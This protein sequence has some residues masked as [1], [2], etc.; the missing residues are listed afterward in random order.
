MRKIKEVLRLRAFGRSQ[1]EIARSCRMPRRTV[2]M[3][4][5][6]AGA[7]DLSYEDVA[8]WSDGQL[9]AHLFARV[10]TNRRPHPDWGAV[11]SAM[12][13]RAVTLRLLW[14]EYREETPDGLGYTQ[15]V[16]HFRAWEQ[17]QGAARL[18]QQF[19][20]GDRVEV[21]YA[22]MTIQV[23]LGAESRPAQVFVGVLPYSAY[24]FADVTETQSLGD[25]IA[26]HIR[27]FEYLGGVPRSIVPDNLKAGV[28][29]ACFYDPTINLTYRDLAIH[30][31]TAVIPTRVRRPRDKGAVENAVGQVERRAL[32]PLRHHQF[33]SVE[34]AR[35]AVLA[36]VAVINAAMLTGV[37]GATRQGLF[38]ETEKPTLRALPPDRF[39]HGTWS[40]CTVRPHYHVEV[41]GVFYSVPYRLIGE[42]VDIH[43]TA[44]L[45]T[46]FR[47]GER[48]ACHRRGTSNAGKHPDGPSITVDAH[49]PANH[50]AMDHYTVEGVAV[51]LEAIGPSSRAVYARQCLDA[52]HPTQAMRLGRGLLRLAARHGAERLEDACAAAL[53]A[54]VSSLRY[55]D[56]LL[57][58]AAAP[59]PANEGVGDHANLRGAAYYS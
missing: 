45:V 7:A 50:R 57:R 42:K 35:S 52:D 46:V 49:R 48:V 47:R 12:R 40:R 14:E 19:A 25:W 27:L 30:Y 43:A 36:K 24:I 34:E 10:P 39:E 38:D 4:L 37:P 15:F 56:T 2:R 9:E 44:Q 29:Q 54:N 53:A 51:E 21:D 16:A 28:T 22:G 20:P 31:G 3:Y 17:E 6:R 5:E 58:Q 41:D 23:G 55:I 8:S 26:S 1:R 59:A 11:A 33:A 13:G 18:R 32:A